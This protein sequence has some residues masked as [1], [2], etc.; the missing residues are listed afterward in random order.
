MLKIGD[1]V[2]AVQ[3]E[4]DG[5]VPRTL[6]REVM[7]EGIIVSFHTNHIVVEAPSGEIYPCH[8]SPLV[9]EKDESRLSNEIRDF[10]SR[11]RKELLNKTP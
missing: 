7:V 5:R 4:D 3:M 8:Y 1:Y 11:R 10:I 9:K 2:H 6:N